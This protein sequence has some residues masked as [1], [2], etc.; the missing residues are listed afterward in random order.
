MVGALEVAY[1]SHQNESNDANRLDDFRLPK[2][3]AG[4]A[5]KSDAYRGMTRRL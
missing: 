5:V 4:F 2:P 1:A 3:L